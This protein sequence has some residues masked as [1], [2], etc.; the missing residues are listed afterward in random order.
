LAAAYREYQEITG[1]RWE[2]PVKECLYFGH[3]P[4]PAV[5]FLQ[6]S[7]AALVGDVAS[8]AQA[9]RHR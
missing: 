9:G 5:P 3:I 7:A 2:K 8:S 6:R 1:R 4:T